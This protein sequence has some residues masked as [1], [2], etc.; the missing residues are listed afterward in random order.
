MILLARGGAA[1]KELYKRALYA[2]GTEE[3]DR[4]VTEKKR[5]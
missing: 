1:I 4:K 5:Y 3:R 2:S